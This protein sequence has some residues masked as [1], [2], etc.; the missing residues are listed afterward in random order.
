MSTPKPPLDARIRLAV[1]QLTPP[2][3]WNALKRAKGA[4]SQPATPEPATPPSLPPEWEYVPE[5]W[6]RPT[7]GWDVDAVVESYMEKWS[8]YVAALRGPK[9]LGVYHEVVAGASVEPQDR[10][11]HNM[12]VSYGYVLARA[13]RGRAR[14]SL[15][16]W[17]GGLGHY[18]ALS[19]ALLPDLEIEYH[20]RELPKV[21]A[22]GRE[23]FPAASSHASRVRSASPA[24][25][26]STMR[27]ATSSG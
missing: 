15:L 3:V 25:T 24:S 27:P 10:E 8:S 6:G 4:Q 7:Q 11:A 23:L 14:L 13:A 21:A 18:F 20:C 17:G 9:P 22:A 2:V 5:G 16:D 19:T 1:K 26:T 12:L